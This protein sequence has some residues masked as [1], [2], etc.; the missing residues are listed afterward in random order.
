MTI[1]KTFKDS[2]YF[3]EY[4]KI[5]TTKKLKPSFSIKLFKIISIGTGFDFGTEEQVDTEYSESIAKETRYQDRVTFIAEPQRTTVA[6]YYSFR[7]TLRIPYTLKLRR[8]DGKT[9]DVKGMYEGVGYTEN[10]LDVNEYALSRS[11]EPSGAPISHR[12]IDLRNRK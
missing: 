1:D 8:A 7:H 3:R 4:K 11:G 5:T 9:L 12:T 6:T 10:R 2:T